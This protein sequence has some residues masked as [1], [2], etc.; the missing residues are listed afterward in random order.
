MEELYLSV[1]SIDQIRARVKE[2]QKNYKSNLSSLDNFLNNQRGYASRIPKGEDVITLM[3]GGLDS[4]IMVHKMI[5]DWGVRVHPLFV[6]RSSRNEKYEEEAFDFFVDFYQRRFPKNFGDP[7]KITY[8]VPPQEFKKGF[9]KNLSKTVGLPLRNSTLQNL[10]VM[11]AVSLQTKGI[12]A[13]TIFSGSVAEDNTEPELGLLSLRSQTINTCINMGD[14]RWQITS[15]LT[16]TNLVESPV[17]KIDLI[18]YAFQKFIP[19]DKTRTCFSSDEI[20]DGT[21]NACQKR[22]AA[23]KHLNMLDPIKYQEVK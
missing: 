9:S 5:E 20:A 23:F 17:Y 7:Q 4:S 13:K 16:D 1:E 11:Y 21:C 2:A 6:K 19:I 10:A 15:P 12:D 22:L 8:Q 3:S 18:E 14:W